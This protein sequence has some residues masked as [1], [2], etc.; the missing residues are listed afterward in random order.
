[1]ESVQEGS[2]KSGSQSFPQYSLL[3]EIANSS[4]ERNFEIQCPLEGLVAMPK[5][6]IPHGWPETDVFVLHEIPR[7]IKPLKLMDDGLVLRRSRK[8]SEAIVAM[9]KR[10]NVIIS[11]G[12]E[13]SLLMR[14]SHAART[15]KGIGV[16]SDLSKG[17][18]VLDL[19][20]SE[21][22]WL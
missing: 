18:R 12:S 4:V 22:V 1:M 7:R 2:K 15:A 3:F 19:R 17:M 16:A 10:P 8:R 11:A 6:H 14:F 13:L 21:T 5:Q 20:K 9:R